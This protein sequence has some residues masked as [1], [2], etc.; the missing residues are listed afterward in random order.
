M[1]YRL[2][3]RSG[4]RVS[5]ICLGTMTF[6]RTGSDGDLATYRTIFDAFAEAG[7]NF[8]DTAHFYGD[9]AS[10]QIVGDFIRADRDHF[11]LATKYTPLNS[12]D[13]ARSGNNRKAMMKMVEDSL[14]R[15][16]TEFIDLLFLHMWDDTT[17]IDEIMRAFDDLVTA[18]KV[19]YVGCSNI[20]A[21]QVSRANMLADLRGW[22]SFIGLQVE[23]SLAQRQ[24]EH[25]LL[26]MAKALDIGVT[27][28]SPLGGGLLLER[29][30]PRRPY[31]RDSEQAKALAGLVTAIAREVGRSP[32]QVAIAALRQLPWHVIPVMG[33]SSVEQIRDTLGCID[34]VLD[35]D[36]LQRLDAASAIK[37]I[38][39]HDFL[40]MP[41]IQ[42]IMLGDNPP[43]NHRR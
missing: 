39:P 34:L 29:D 24:A 37:P 42:R 26:P 41:M 16:D 4:L 14:R 2:L 20:P 30:G 5:E 23:Y 3:G 38:Y 18:G 22:A 10:E 13:V 15:L 36:Q 11:V 27:A 6:S 21:W 35:H 40:H 12:G 7:G 8:I 9:G 1:H 33:A 19:H 31:L 17:P 28:W 25:D 43:Q 32:A